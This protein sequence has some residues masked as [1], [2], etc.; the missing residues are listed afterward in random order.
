MAHSLGIIGM[1][2]HHFLPTFL[3]KL[4]PLHVSDFPC[5]GKPAL[6][7]EHSLCP[8]TLF[9]PTSSTCACLKFQCP[10][11]TWVHTGGCTP[12]RWIPMGAP[13]PR[14]PPI[15]AC[16]KHGDPLSTPRRAPV[17]VPPW[18]PRIGTPFCYLAITLAK[19]CRFQHCQN[20]QTHRP[21]IPAERPKPFI[22]NPPL[23]TSQVR[24]KYG[25]S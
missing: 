13:L 24:I 7:A 1:W 10:G 18:T 19:T 14:R 8:D 6:E 4:A 21:K 16:E 17:Q 9:T 20:Q 15:L 11:T 25:L 23:S 2:S 3:L 22:G 5:F 12:V